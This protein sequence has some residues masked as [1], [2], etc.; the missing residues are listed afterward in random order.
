ME[1]KRK[2]TRSEKATIAKNKGKSPWKNQ[3][4]SMVTGR[5]KFRGIF[6]DEESHRGLHRQE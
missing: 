2:L 1:K 4:R 6:L 3:M 5:G